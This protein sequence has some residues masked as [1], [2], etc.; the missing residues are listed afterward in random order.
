MKHVHLEKCQQKTP[1]NDNYLSYIKHS[2]SVIFKWTPPLYLIQNRSI[3]CSHHCKNYSSQCWQQNVTQLHNSVCVH[4]DRI[5]L[6]KDDKYN[7]KHTSLSVMYN[8]SITRM[9]TRLY[10]TYHTCTIRHNIMISC[11]YHIIVLITW[12][13]VAHNFPLVSLSTC[14]AHYQSYSNPQTHAQ[15]T[16]HSI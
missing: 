15:H 13:Y 7:T 4:V 6:S 5:S 1:W 8:A 9:Q 16:D 11:W 3:S 12:W 2:L 10:A 14:Q